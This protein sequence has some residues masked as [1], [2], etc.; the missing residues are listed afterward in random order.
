MKGIYSLVIW[1]LPAIL[2]PGILGWTTVVPDLPIPGIAPPAVDRPVQ[3][4]D[5]SAR[6]LEYRSD[7][8]KMVV[9]N[10]P[11]DQI[12]INSFNLINNIWGAPQNETI[13]TGIYLNEDGVFG[14]QWDRSS[15]KIG[16]EANAILPIYP[17]VRI[18]GN[19]WERTVAQ[20]FPLNLADTQALTF[21]IAFNYTSAP[22]G[23]YDLAYDMF[24][25]APDQPNN[26]PGI[27]A[28]V[29]IWMD[30]TQG[31]PKQH[32]KGDF[33]DG[34]NSFALYSWPMAD[35]RA[36][37]SFILKKTAAGQGNYT[38]DAKKLLDQLN[39][40]NDLLIHGVEFGNE[41]WN[42]SGKVEIR[43][44]SISV[45]GNVLQ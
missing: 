44:F 26:K 16:P 45:N 21:N 30:G 13:N 19:R 24:L 8:I 27:K 2:L 37:Y 17:S 23:A 43:Q 9:K 6:P 32:Y 33:S 29:M 15:P 31:Q 39:L 7:I 4:A 18:G 1:L 40:D 35:G 14:W 5:S 36:Y 11:Y 34:N 41:V 28:E 10:K 3:I 22:T 25:S 38:I 20:G 12:N 42:G